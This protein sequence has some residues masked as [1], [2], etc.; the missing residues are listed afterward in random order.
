MGTVNGTLDLMMDSLMG[1]LGPLLSLLSALPKIQTDP[2]VVNQMW[3]AS[4]V[5]IPI[6]Q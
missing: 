3:N 2:Q 1:S 4:A 6:F 5:H